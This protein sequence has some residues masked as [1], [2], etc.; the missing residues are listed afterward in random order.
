MLRDERALSS[1][2]ARLGVEVTAGHTENPFANHP[3]GRP[4]M[5]EVLVRFLPISTA[6]W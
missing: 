6:L 5:L 3:R 4:E 1:L 2:R